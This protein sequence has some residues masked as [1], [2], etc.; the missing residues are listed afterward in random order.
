MYIP[1]EP[2]ITFGNARVL[3]CPRSL[4]INSVPLYKPMIS[5]INN[6]NNLH[7]TDIIQNT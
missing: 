7:F 3:V 2:V 1:T 4:K 6:H 5:R